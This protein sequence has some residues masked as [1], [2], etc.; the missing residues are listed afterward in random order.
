MGSQTVLVGL[1]ILGFVGVV[2]WQIIQHWR[3]PKWDS[4]NYPGL[5]R[6]NRWTLGLRYLGIAIGLMVLLMSLAVGNYGTGLILAP[7]VTACIILICLI[8][9]EVKSFSTA[10]QPGVAGLEQRTLKHYLNWPLLVVLVAL[11]I[12]LGLVMIWTA[13]L[14]DETGRRFSV[15][16]VGCLEPGQNDVMAAISPF[17]GG[18]YS[19]LMLIVLGLA[20][21]LA[22]VAMFVIVGRAR[23]GADPTLA[24]WD[25]ALRRRNARA[26]IITLLAATSASLFVAVAGLRGAYD[27]LRSFDYS[28]PGPVI[29]SELSP[30]IIKVASVQVWGLN[31]LSL[32]EVG[33]ALALL[34]LATGLLVLIASTGLLID[35]RLD[36]YR[37]KKV[38]DATTDGPDPSQTELEVDCEADLETKGGKKS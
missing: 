10:R 2:S 11:T 12:A 1:V 32:R 33:L 24:Q 13:G 4:S 9:G 38:G 6:I 19:R 23:N 31:L 37:D 36:V 22:V 16:C 28:G 15:N 20:W 18:S 3:R 25:D 26:V 35:F 5:T 8:I 30:G 7:A 21:A 27:T 14:A 17:L 34:Y 29:F